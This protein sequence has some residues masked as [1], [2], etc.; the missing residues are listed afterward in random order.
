MWTAAP[1]ASRSCSAGSSP[2]SP[3]PSA[4]SAETAAPPNHPSA[5]PAPLRSPRAPPQPFAVPHTDRALAAAPYDGTARALITALKFSHRLALADMAAAAI[6]AKAAPLTATIVPVPPDPWRHRLRGFD[7][8]AE[9]AAALSRRTDLPLSHCLVRR[10]APRQVGKARSERLASRHHVRTH[11]LAPPT[12]ILL[13]DVATTGATLAECA[14]ALR[15][16]GCRR[17]PCPYVR[18]GVASSES[19]RKE[20]RVRIEVRG[21]H[22]EVTDELR[23]AVAKRFAR[24][25]KQVSG[26]GHPRRRALR[27]AQPLDSRQPDRR[28]DPPREGQDASRK[29]GVPRDAPLDPRGG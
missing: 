17:N 8:A 4:P 29:G 19:D 7:P 11:G 14:R 13:D 28:G 23:E 18:T 20:Q 26:T 1:D 22:F 2:S 15:V 9:I 10:H 24:T 12:V 3:R 25:G 5:T 6:Q 16:A 21:R 27:G